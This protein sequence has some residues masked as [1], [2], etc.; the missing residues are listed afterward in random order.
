MLMS[1]PASRLYRSATAPASTAAPKLKQGPQTEISVAKAGQV[2]ML[3]QMENSTEWLA[4][5][6]KR[7][8][9]G[10]DATGDPRLKVSVAS[11]C[12]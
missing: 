11:C 9:Y 10:S 2:V 1:P 6:L 3:V 12:L 7:F 8:I 4:A 5:M